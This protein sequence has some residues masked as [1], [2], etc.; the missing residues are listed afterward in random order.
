MI[1]GFAL[2]TSSSS[3]QS[4][5]SNASVISPLR[6]TVLLPSPKSIRPKTF[7]TVADA[8]L[9]GQRSWP[10]CSSSAAR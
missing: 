8:Q 4:P 7:A 10:F 9:M 3:T 1:F 6:N 2:S 5:F